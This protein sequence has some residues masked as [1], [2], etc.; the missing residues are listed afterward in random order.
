MALIFNLPVF[1]QNG[2]HFVGNGGLATKVQ[3]VTQE[4]SLYSV[5][6]YKKIALTMQIKKS[7][8]P[9]DS[10]LNISIQK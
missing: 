9:T 1:V 10:H 7:Y 8:L 4:G 3:N 5:S 6:L 2:G